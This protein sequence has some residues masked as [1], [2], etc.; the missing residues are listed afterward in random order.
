[1]TDELIE[2]RDRVG[3]FMDAL[4]DVPCREDRSAAYCGGWEEGQQA[5]ASIRERYTPEEQVE[6]ID[7]AVNAFLA[8][9]RMLSL[10]ENE[11]DRKR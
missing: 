4:D 7:K 10:V 2:L 5:L 3:G 1:M 6:V 8:G 11:G 9:L